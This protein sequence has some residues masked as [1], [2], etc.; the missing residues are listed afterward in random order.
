[1]G[2]GARLRGFI[3]EGEGA[4]GA[5]LGRAGS[6]S[7]EDDFQDV[8]SAFFDDE[9]AGVVIEN[10]GMVGDAERLSLSLGLEIA[11]EKS[12]VLGDV[13][14]KSSL[15]A[16]RYSFSFRLDFEG[17]IGS[18]NGGFSSA[19]VETIIQSSAG[20]CNPYPRV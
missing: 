1:M 3:E 14:W 11:I 4:V 9:L 18:E 13:E 2:E 19:G 12:G 15:C 20:G 8:A 10:F 16:V 5:V 6:L 7:F 17:G